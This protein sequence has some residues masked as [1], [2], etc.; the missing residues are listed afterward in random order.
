M[1]KVKIGDKAPDFT[2]QSCASEDIRLSKFFGKKNVVLFFYPRDEGPTC[3]KEAEAFRNNYEAFK[4]RN[5]EVIGISAQNAESHKSFANHHGLQ[6]ILLSDV[7]N[8]VRKLYGVSSTLVCR[9]G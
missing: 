9:G 6:F 1:V 4:E 2:L 3:V 7:D 5:A 8:K